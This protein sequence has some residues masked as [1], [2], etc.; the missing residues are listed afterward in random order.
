MES[1]P[2]RTRHPLSIGLVLRSGIQL[3]G[4][5]I[6]FVIMTADLGFR[7]Q[8]QEDT[9]KDMQAMIAE[10]KSQR[11]PDCTRSL[12]TGVDSPCPPGGQESEVD[13]PSGCPAYL[14]RPADSGTKSAPIVVLREI[15]AHVYKGHRRLLQQNMNL[16]LVQLGLI[17]E[18]VAK[19]LTKL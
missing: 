12:T 7:L 4:I 16:D 8:R 15:N 13:E 6:F 3:N 5:S 1:P 11:Q 9:I 19:D 10:L 14:S 17:D 2:R 18:H